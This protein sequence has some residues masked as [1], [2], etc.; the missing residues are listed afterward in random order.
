MITSTSTCSKLMTTSSY[1]GVGGAGG[2]K[3]ATWQM[4]WQHYKTKAVAATGSTRRVQ[5]TARS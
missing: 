1:F 3:S 5:Y 4:K 2:G